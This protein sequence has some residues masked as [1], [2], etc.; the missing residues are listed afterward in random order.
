MKGDKKTFFI[1]RKYFWEYLENWNSNIWRVR[2]REQVIS[3]FLL[4]ACFDL[5]SSPLSSF[6]ENSNHGSENYLKSGLRIPALEGQKIF[7]PF[8][9]HFQ[10]LHKKLHIFVFYLFWISWF[11]NQISIKNHFQQ[12]IWFLNN[13]TRYQKLVK[14]TSFNCVR[15]WK[16]KEKWNKTK[17]CLT[18]QSGGSNPIFSVNFLTTIWIFMESE[19]D[20][21]KYRK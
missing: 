5:I 21:I 19:G 14:I 11:T 3:L 10:I 2:C 17:N 6:Y 4:E 9:V 20:E 18:F 16:W 1:G 12:F 13:K 15:I 8:S 7:C